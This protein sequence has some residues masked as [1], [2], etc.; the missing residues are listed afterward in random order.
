MSRAKVY[1]VD[2]DFKA[3][4]SILSHSADEAEMEATLV[5][6]NIRRSAIKS[7]LRMEIKSVKPRELV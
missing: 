1:Q 2:I 3:V 6:D 4:V 5:A 7:G